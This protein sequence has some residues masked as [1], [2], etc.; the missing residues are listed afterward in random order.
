MF[1][2]S[3]EYTFCEY[4]Y[5]LCRSLCIGFFNDDQVALNF[6]LVSKLLFLCIYGP[7]WVTEPFRAQN[8]DAIVCMIHGLLVWVGGIGI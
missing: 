1:A 7:F 5:T 2:V 6:S 3:I 4:D 8:K